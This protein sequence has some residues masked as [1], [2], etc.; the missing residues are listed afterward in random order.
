MWS[1]YSLEVVDAVARN[2]SFSAAAGV[3]SRSF[4]GQLY[5]ASAGRVLAVPLFERRHRDVEL[6]AAGAWFLKEGRS[7]VKNADHPAAMSA[8]SERLARSVSYR[9]G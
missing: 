6:T 7:V 3:A 8:D 2:G 1:E 9:S 4:C 5:R